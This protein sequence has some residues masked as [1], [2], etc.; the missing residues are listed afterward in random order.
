VAK[1]RPKQ[2]VWEHWCPAC[3]RIHTARGDF[4]GNMSSPTFGSTFKVIRGPVGSQVTCHYRITSG[5]ILYDLDC[6]HAEAGNIVAMVD[7]PE[8]A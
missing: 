2:A 7:I 8:G 6:S 3:E 1:L 5:S 4:D